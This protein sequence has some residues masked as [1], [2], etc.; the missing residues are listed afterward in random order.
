MVTG[1]E[2]PGPMPA[3]ISGTGTGIFINGREIHSADQMALYRLLGVTYQGR[4]LLDAQGNLT[5]EQGQFLV[6]LAAAAQSAGGQKGGLTSGAGGTVGVDGS[7]GVLFYTP[8][9]SGYKSWNN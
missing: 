5:T 8:S 6:N 2:L 1:L 9:G 3:D 4:Y 7:G